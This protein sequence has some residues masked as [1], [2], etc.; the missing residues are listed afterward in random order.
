MLSSGLDPEHIDSLL[1]AGVERSAV[2]G[3]VAVVVDRDGVCY[4]A[5]FGERE[6]GSGVPMTVDTVGSIFS[7]TKALTAAAAMQLVER[8][9]L[10]LDTPAGDVCAELAQVL[11]EVVGEGVVVVDHE[12]HRCRSLAAC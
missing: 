8:G 5:A 3:V 11:H 4:E 6:L 1:Q 10:S 7:M 9:Q 2:P 12:N